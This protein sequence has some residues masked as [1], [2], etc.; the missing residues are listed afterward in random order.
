MPAM[1]SITVKKAD[2]TTD[3]VYGALTGAGSDNSPAVWRQD[4]GQP[5]TLP[6]GLRAWLMIKSLWNGNK[7]ARKIPI[8]YAYPYAIQDTT[9]QKWSAPD[10]FRFNGEAIVPQGMPPA[11]ISEAVHQCFNLV[12]SALSKSSAIDGYAPNQ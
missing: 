12:A 10:T 11:Q 2:G 8:S 7:T 6:L 9:T 1:A 3:V 4:A 5:A